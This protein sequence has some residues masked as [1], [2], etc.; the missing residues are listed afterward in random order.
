VFFQVRP[1]WSKLR[2]R[3]VLALLLA[4][5]QVG[6]ECCASSNGGLVLALLA[7]FLLPATAQPGAK[8]M[9]H[10]LV[11]AK[12]SMLR[13]LL[14]LALRQVGLECCASSNGTVL[15]A[16]ALRQVGPEC[17]ASSN[18]GPV[19]GLLGLVRLATVVLATALRQV[20][21]LLAT[22]SQV[23]ATWSTPRLLYS[24]KPSLS[25]YSPLRNRECHGCR[26]QPCAGMLERRKRGKSRCSDRK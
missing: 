12:W 11:A 19:L 6:L 13:R 24:W 7:T 22:A 17:C 26:P 20:V 5:R 23:F 16:T 10:R 1:K 14:L 9:P 2:L 18:G 3:Q 15:L 8:T 21:A 4:L 25:E